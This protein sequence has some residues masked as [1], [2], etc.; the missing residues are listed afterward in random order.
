MDYAA[1]IPL[2][3]FLIAVQLAARFNLH[4]LL[5]AFV[6]VGLPYCITLLL[7]YVHA[8]GYNIPILPNLFTISSIVTVV[9]Q[10]CIA[11]F[12]FKKIRD[13]ESIAQTAA[14]SVGGFVVISFVIPYIVS[15][16]PIF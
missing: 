10:F 4:S 7:R 6:A 8:V 3:T 11:I 5:L 9:A 1:L 15:L 2:L 16:V 13:E 12:I 14:W